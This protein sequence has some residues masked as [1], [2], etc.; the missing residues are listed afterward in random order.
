MLKSPKVVPGM[1]A[2]VIMAGILSAAI[3]AMEWNFKEYKWKLDE[4]SRYGYMHIMAQEGLTSQGCDRC[5]RWAF[6]DEY[7]SL[8]IMESPKA[9]NMRHRDL[10]VMK[11]T[12]YYERT[13]RR[14]ARLCKESS[15]IIY[16]NG[17]DWIA[18][19]LQK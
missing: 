18:Y 4:I 9:W 12:D 17:T 15:G 14:I 1:M 8:R 5:M 10:F 7:G 3:L 19:D 6:G 11:D 16:F 2:A 13:L